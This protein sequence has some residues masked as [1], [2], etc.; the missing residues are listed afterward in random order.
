MRKSV[1]NTW[2]AT[3]CSLCLLGILTLG[4]A[5]PAIGASHGPRPELTVTSDSPGFEKGGATY[6]GAGAALR[7]RLAVP[8][9]LT[10]V[11]SASTVAGTGVD[12]VAKDTWVEVP[13]DDT[14]G[15]KVYEAP[16]TAEEAVSGARA[17]V[18]VRGEEGEQTAYEV[19]CD[20]SVAIDGASPMLGMR[21]SQERG[22]SDSDGVDYYAK[23]GLACELTVDDETF[24][25][26]KV[27]VNGAVLQEDAWSSD[28]SR[29]TAV[30]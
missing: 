28:G 22:G 12:D 1:N 9:G 19:V 6:Y 10:F 16:L 27:L 30:I 26:N 15:A 14:G 18:V 29:H 13:S 5:A 3:A 17:H 20:Q 11:A 23:E 8:E 24:A 25:A 7:A 4:A 2:A 21:M